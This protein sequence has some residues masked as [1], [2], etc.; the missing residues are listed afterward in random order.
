MTARAVSSFDAR[1][2]PGDSPVDPCS[3]FRSAS[4][5]KLDNAKDLSGRIENEEMHV[6]D[7][8]QSPHVA[9]SI[10]QMCA[11]AA[12]LHPGIEA[13]LPL[14][15]MPK[16]SYAHAKRVIDIVCAALALVVLSPVFAACAIAV[17]ATSEGPV[18]FRQ[19][20]WGRKH[21]R[22]ECWKFRTMIGETPPNMPAASFEDKAAF[23][24]PV[25]DFLR[26]WSLDELP[27]LVNIIRGEIPFRIVKTDQGEPCEISGLFA[28]PAM[29]MR[30]GKVLFPQVKV[31]SG[32]SLR[33]VRNI[34]SNLTAQRAQT[35]RVYAKRKF[36]PIRG[37]YGFACNMSRAC[38]CVVFQA[39]R[40]GWNV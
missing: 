12:R 24:T 6:E 35:Q 22:F 36:A 3:R 34:F 14:S 27:Q 7:A 23:M 21:T 20:R 37:F 13:H 26:R 11:M 18:F 39:T 5:G 29:E 2:S 17:R 16:K 28:L 30:T 8:A 25:G 33:A 38:V 10:G 19:Q 1:V 15:R 32:T 31:T 40:T 4:V 9:P